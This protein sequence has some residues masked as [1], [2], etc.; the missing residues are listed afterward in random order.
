MNRWNLS[1]KFVISIVLSSAILFFGVAGLA[2]DDTQTPSEEIGTGAMEV[3]SG[4]LADSDVQS[5]SAMISEAESLIDDGVPPGIVVAIVRSLETGHLSSEELGDTFGDLRENVVNGDKAPGLVMQ[6]IK[7]A[8][9]LPEDVG[10]PEEKGN[11]DEAGPPEEKGGSDEAGPPE[12]K[13]NSDDAGPPEE[14]GNS[15]EAGPPEGEK[16]E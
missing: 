11:S 13:G 8:Y 2:Q 6:S 14:K 12:E 16:E 3:I 1:P 7:A 5:E 9:Q 15:D 10:K 4:V